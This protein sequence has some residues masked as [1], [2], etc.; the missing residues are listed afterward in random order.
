MA[1][2]SNN[3]KNP[4][5]REPL[6]AA[7]YVRMSTEHQKYSTENQS[8]A[9]G[10][11]AS[12]RN[13]QIVRTYEDAGKSGLNLAG[14]NSLQELL[15]DVET[16]NADFDSV[17]VYDV[18]RWGR[19][20]DTD[21]SAF[22]EYL[23]KRANIQVEYCAEQFANDGSLP[24]NVLK[25]IKRAMAGEYSRELSIKVFSGQCRLIELGFRQGGPAGFGLRRQLVDQHG[26][27][28]QILMQ[29]EYK[30][31]QTDRVVLVPGPEEEIQVVREIYDLLTKHGVLEAEIAHRF[32][33]RGV[34]TDL[35]KPWT[36]G[37]VHQILTNPKYV[38]VNVY[39]RRS[40]KL[41]K[42]R[43]TNP[44]E[45]WICRT[46]AFEAIVSQDQFECAQCII[47]ARHEYYSDDD[48]LGKLRQLLAVTG[49]LSGILIDECET[50]PSSSAYRSRFKSLLRAYQLIGYTP[51]RD[52]RYIET[53]KAL[54]QLHKDL[55]EKVIADLR[56]LGATV[57]QSHSSLLLEINE[58]WTASL[59]LARCQET[60]RGDCRWHFRFD[61]SLDPDITVAVRMAPGNEKAFDYYLFPRLSDLESRIRLGANNG[62][63]LDV[64]RYDNLDFF[65]YLS[66]QRCI[67]EVA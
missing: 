9:I 42:K 54:R 10:R 1:D 60:M 37:T 15:K 63:L 67:E 66:R 62:L 30:S 58:S 4:V 39:N 2:G 16:G 3:T 29:G 43:V 34:A 13:I 8:D 55:Y 52:Y 14:R 11:Y 21:E 18:S 45:M 33:Q 47:Q 64:Y 40:F 38:G 23:C 56:A 35:G 26:T 22:Y 28:K 31:L 17:L 49:T 65:S 50:M 61:R 51:G 32:N 57:H 36:R 19:F 20:Q 24:S 5:P 41:K 53:N 25:T 27:P 12:A 46:G 48:L 6:R 44:P 59:V 7:Q